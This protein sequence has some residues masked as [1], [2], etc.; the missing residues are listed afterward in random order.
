MATTLDV[1]RLYSAADDHRPVVGTTVWAVAHP[2]GEAPDGPDRRWALV[3]GE[4]MGVRLDTPDW[5][6]G[7]VWSSEALCREHAWSRHVVGRRHLTGFD[8]LLLDVVT[9]TLFRIASR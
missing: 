3:M 8:V 5:P 1:P 7:Q 9:P 4:V 2:I 6:N